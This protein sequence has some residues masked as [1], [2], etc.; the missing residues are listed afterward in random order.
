MKII[1]FL[2]VAIATLL[3]SVSVNAEN[4]EF[5]DAKVKELCVANWDTNGDGEF[6]Y[7]EASSVTDIGGVFEGD[8]T[9]IKFEEL[10]YFSSLTKIADKAFSGCSRL[11]SI[12]IPDNV[13]ILGE[14]AF[15]ECI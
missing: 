9:I 3:C 10:Q 4:I 15:F 5:A 14:K 8:T 7:V 1:R 2:F 12:N 13:S 6:S 11:L